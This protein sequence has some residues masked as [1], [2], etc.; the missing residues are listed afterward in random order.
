MPERLIGMAPRSLAVAWLVLAYLLSACST[1][2]TGTG[3]RTYPVLKTP[4][5]VTMTNADGGKSKSVAQG[6]IFQVD[7]QAEQGWEPFS[8]PVSSDGGIAA[9]LQ[10]R[11]RS[12]QGTTSAMAFAALWPGIVRINAGSNNKCPRTS[13]TAGQ[14]AVCSVQLHRFEVTVVV[15]PGRRPTFELAAGEWSRQAD[16]KLIPGDRVF[17]S[18][19]AAP[20]APTSDNSKALS[21]AGRDSR[22]FYT[23]KAQSAGKARLGWVNDPCPST[24]P[25]FPRCSSSASVFSVNVVVVVPSS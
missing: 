9:P 23:F 17:V 13:P 25:F 18:T 3:S 21:A 20:E 6:D 15:G 16:Y 8:T 19:S 5:A 4:P 22:G 14:I 12:S 1:A 10:A 7:L 11:P 2:S 24:V